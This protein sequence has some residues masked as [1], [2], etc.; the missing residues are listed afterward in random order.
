VTGQRS[1]I[2]DGGTISD[3]ILNKSRNE[4]AT[5]IEICLSPMVAADTTLM[6][7]ERVKMSP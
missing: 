3:Q 7:D 2:M 1:R 5:S 6:F 4:I